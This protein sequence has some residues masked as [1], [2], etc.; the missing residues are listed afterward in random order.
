M[1]LAL[2]RRLW[3]VMAGARKTG[4]GG[5]CEG[6]ESLHFYVSEFVLGVIVGAVGLLAVLT[7]YG[8]HIQRKKRG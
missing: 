6:G 1:K 4:K 3:V 7:A 5:M 2:R 8:V